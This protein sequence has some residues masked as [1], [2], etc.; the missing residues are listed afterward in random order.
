[1][2]TLKIPNRRRCVQRSGLWRGLRQAIGIRG[3]VDGLGKGGRGGLVRA[4]VPKGVR[5]KWAGV[6]ECDLG[7]GGGFPGVN[8]E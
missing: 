2:C 8:R 6:G 3:S 7:G 1:M 4:K 5:V